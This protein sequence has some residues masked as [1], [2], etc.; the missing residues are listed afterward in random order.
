MLRYSKSAENLGADAA[1]EQLEF[2]LFGSHTFGRHNLM[3]GGQYNTS[4]DDNVPIY[5]LFS[6][7][8]FLNMSG[9]ENNSLIGSN[10]GMAIAGYRYQVVQSG[11]LPGY[12]GATLEYG[13]AA[14]KRSE[15]FTDGLLNG[16]VYFAYRTPLG[17][18]Y[19]G[20]GWSEEQSPLYFLQLGWVFGPS[21]LGRR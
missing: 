19:L 15:I 1:Y 3:W 7:G 18:V 20:V 12:V 10:Y 2:V 17:P 4:L 8:G 6:G 21:R 14:Q 13:N 5:T 11:F 9:F 16:S